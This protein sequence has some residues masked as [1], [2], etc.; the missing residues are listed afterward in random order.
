MEFVLGRERWLAYLKELCSAREKPASDAEEIWAN[1]LA[2]LAD[3]D[4]DV[5]ELS[6]DGFDRAVREKLDLLVPPPAKSRDGRSK[7]GLLRKRA[8]PEMSAGATP[9]PDAVLG[10]AA[11]GAQDSNTFR[12]NIKKGFVPLPDSLTFEGLFHDYFFEN[13]EAGTCASLF[14]PSYARAL[15][16]DPE[17][18]HLEYF[19]AV[20]LDSGVRKLDF[21]RKRL[22]LCLLIDVSGSMDS[23]FDRYYYDGRGRQV[24]LGAS[25]LQESK[26]KVALKTAARLLN[27]LKPEDKLGLVFFADEAEE[28]LTLTKVRRIPMSK[29]KKKLLTRTTAGGT[30]LES[31]LLC[32]F[33][34]LEK[35]GGKD[36]G[37]GENRVIVLTDEMPNL[38]EV[39]AEGLRMLV[40]AKASKGIFTTFIG[41]GLDF[42]SQL[43][44]AITDTRGANYFSVHSPKEFK[45]RLNSEFDFMVTPMVFD[46]ELAISGARIQGVFGSPQA[47]R[48]TGRLMRV[49]TLF[50]SARQ[51]GRSR[52]GLILLRLAS[53][54]ADGAVRLQASWQDRQG[55]QD[56]VSR[57][58][59][60]LSES[61]EFYEHAGLRKGILLVRYALLLRE[62]MESEHQRAVKKVPRFFILL[63]RDRV[64]VREVELP[65]SDWERESLAQRPDETWA[66]R[67]EAFK[68][69]FERE[70]K[71]IQDKDLSQDRKILKILCGALAPREV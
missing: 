49:S 57:D 25:E 59:G 21:A 30:N 11:G 58:L 55:V 45:K 54:D 69:H 5:Q 20:G 28:A 1:C 61:K 3:E 67:F 43:V 18:R 13:G 2:L 68:R 8:M 35:G 6:Q 12:D 32:A 71:I 17:S 42:H 53:E 56:S 19:L 34:M 47:D 52:G 14:C 41:V 22:S 46:L 37:I 40:D 26:L 70:E 16:P 51:Q 36:T 27:L 31:G 50:P 4:L 60:P 65:L 66:K 9:E 7:S 63:E 62:W 29:I 15:S 48:S 33:G 24:E 23:P 44:K 64:E 38:G 10:F 39:T